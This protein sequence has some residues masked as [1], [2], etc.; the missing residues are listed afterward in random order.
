VCWTRLYLYLFYCCHYNRNYIDLEIKPK[1]I[2]QKPQNQNDSSLVGSIS[3]VIWMATFG[4]LFSF[5]GLLFYD[6]FLK[7]LGP[8]Y[9]NYTNGTTV[10]LLMFVL[11]GFAG[12]VLYLLKKQFLNEKQLLK[13]SLSTNALSK[14]M[15]KS[16]LGSKIFIAIAFFLFSP[17]AIFV[18]IPIP[19]GFALPIMIGGTILDIIDIIG[20]RG[21]LFAIISILPAILIVTVNFLIAYLLAGLITSYTKGSAKRRLVS[22]LLFSLY[23]VVTYIWVLLVAGSSYI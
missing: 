19:A 9:N 8:T 12:I 22:I 3:I 21:N 18:G 17:V 11:G 13:L 6:D 1:N 2:E 16:K 14:P 15:T 23:M 10:I 4:A 5:L 7:F 20:G